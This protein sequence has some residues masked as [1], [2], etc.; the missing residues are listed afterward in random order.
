MLIV[1]CLR[2][3]FQ[4]FGALVNEDALNTAANKPVHGKCH[5]GDRCALSSMLRDF[6]RSAADRFVRAYAR[7][8]RVNRRPLGERYFQAIF[9]NRFARRPGAQSFI[10]GII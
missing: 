2:L 7:P 1:P 4:A 5:L 8:N 3:A 9:D 10:K 6:R